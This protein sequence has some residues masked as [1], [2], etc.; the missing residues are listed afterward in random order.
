[1]AEQGVLCAD[2]SR[3]AG[4]PLS[5]T[6]SQ[7][8]VW[9]LLEYRPNWHP[10]ATK[11]GNNTINP[12]LQSHINEAL[13]QVGDARF[14]FI[15][16]LER[17]AGALRCF[18]IFAD[19]LVPRAY[20]L[21]LNRYE[22]LL[23]HP[24]SD[25]LSGRVDEQYRHNEPVYAVCV[26]KERDR[27]CG[28][29]GWSVYNALRELA[30]GQVWQSTHIGGH[31]FAA[32]MVAFPHGTYYGRLEGDDVASIIGAE[33]QANIYLPRLRGRSCYAPQVQAADAFVRETHGLTEYNAMRMKQ[34]TTVDDKT[35]HITFVDR[36]GTQY[37]VK[38]T[39]E[40]SDYVV[41][42]SS[43]DAEP[44]QV[45]YFAVETMPTA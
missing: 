30:G 38:V 17:K 19:E 40:M 37:P 27:C 2:S 34:A 7:Y 43:G 14:L 22:D 8:R 13:E 35:W 33:N 3:E 9:M 28:T 31:R 5:G 39:R 36:S 44:R 29:Y 24:L 16:Q 26:H 18:F 1:M 25:M 6:G 21:D 23:S 41:Y 32:T 45:P 15:R 42:K 20:A 11:Q 4:E 10:K 12:G